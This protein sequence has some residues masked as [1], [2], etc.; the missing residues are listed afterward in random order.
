MI[1][2]ICCLLICSG[3]L[4]GIF[5]G[6]LDA[7][8]QAIL[9]TPADCVSFVLKLGGSI[10]FFCGLI[11]VAEGAGLVDR[12]SRMLAKPVRF[13]MPET[14]RDPE[15]ASA[16]TLNLA[17]NFFGLGNA[18]T[19]Y[20]IK[21]AGRLAYG[22]VRRSLA[23]FMILNTCSVQLIP[24]TICALRQANGSENAMDILPTVWIV[25]V[26]TCAFGILLTR[27]LFME[28]K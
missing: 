17:S 3:T 11:R 19:P 4:C 28:A 21:A 7:V 16:V 27:F 18:A 22:P 15:L 8:S 6:N 23:A 13:L 14:S 25:Q 20:G 1:G 26:L 5:T 9:S 12:F 2:L 10:C 24:T